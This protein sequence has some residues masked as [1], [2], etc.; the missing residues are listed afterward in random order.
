MKKTRILHLI[1]IATLF[2]FGLYAQPT[3]ID[4]QNAFNILDPIDWCSDTDEFTNVDAGDSGY[5]SCWIDGADNDVWFR[6]KAFAKAVNIVINGQGAGATIENPQVA[7]YTGTCGGTL[8]ELECQQDLAGNDIIDAFQGG[9]TIGADYYIRV[10]SELGKEGSF[11][12]CINNYNPPSEP[13]Q[14]CFSSSVLCDKSPFI[15]Q[16]VSGG[17]IDPNEAANSCLGGIFGDSE[18]QS[19]WFNWTCETSG[20][21]TFT[22]SPLNGPDDLDFVLYE[23]PS[24]IQNCGDKTILRCMATACQGPTGLDLTSTDLEED[25]N[26]DPGE[27]GFVKFIDMVA[28]TSYALMINNFSETGLG[29]NMEFGGTGTFL[30]PQADF[31][32]DPDSGLKCDQDFII[33]DLSSFPNGSILEW[34]WNFGE[35]AIPQTANTPGPH[36]V[37]FNSFGEK[38]I[39]LTITTDLGCEVTQVLPLFAEPCCEDLEAIGLDI[40]DVQDLLC[41]GVPGGYIEVDGFGGSPEY[42]YSIDGGPFT[43]VPSF[44]NLLSGNYQ[45]NIVD[46]KGCADSIDVFVDEPAPLFVEAGPDITV[47]LGFDGQLNAV[48]GPSVPITINWTPPDGLSCIDCLDPTV[49]APGTTTYCIEITDDVGCT[50]KD[51]V[52]VRVKIERPVFAPNIFSPNKDGINDFF[53]LFGGPAIANIESLFVFDRWGN[54]MYEAGASLT[55]GDQFSGWDGTFNGKDVNPGVYVWVAEVRF[56]DDVVETITGDITLIK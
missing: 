27:D 50:A 6:F 11:Q 52:T 51:S 14:D 44:D 38:F 42:E 24:G 10:D 26:C 31:S 21:L 48:Y 56:V 2:S 30:G 22:I 35:G 17:G 33:T 1:L 12:I 45:V 13:G 15:V 29:F 41:A 36:S 46:I 28:G 8:N 7:L 20:T 25:L 3:N 39:V 54:R 49:V 32:I 55:P 23:L 40:V 9:L 37:N 5:G 34:E 4:C 16:S 53:N 19:T 47:T 43:E 18:M